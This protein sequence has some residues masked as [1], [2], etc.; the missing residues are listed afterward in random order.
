MVHG[1]R[2]RQARAVR[3]NDAVLTSLNYHQEASHIV[4]RRHEGS[5]FPDLVSTI[6]C[7]LRIAA[8]PVDLTQTSSFAVNPR[9]IHWGH[10]MTP[11][12]LW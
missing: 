2:Y 6:S 10:R 1:E 9:L 8:L 11:R 4:L 3:S 12:E 7:M 5:R